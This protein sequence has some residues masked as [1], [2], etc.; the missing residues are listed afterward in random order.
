MRYAPAPP[1]EPTGPPEAPEVCPICRGA[2]WL[3]KAVPYGDSDFGKLFACRCTQAA[4]AQKH[5]ERLSQASSL[6]AFRDKTFAG[7]VR[8]VSGVQQ[9]YQ[10]AQAYARQPIGWLGLFG[11][12]GCGKTHL[13]AAIAN[14]LLAHQIPVQFVVVPDLLDHLRGAFAPD[15]TVSYDQRFDAVKQAPFLVL[16]DLGTESGTPWAK[17][18][19][20]QLVNHRYNAQLPTVFTSNTRVEQ[21]DPRI[22]SRMHDPGIQAVI[23]TIQAADYRRRRAEPAA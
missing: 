4:Q 13:A 21:L 18:K 20:Y 9:A 7:F 16:D 8:T 23:V 5:A 12:Y 10:R 11:P 6:A 22:A 17:E 19:L 1:A 2:G 15:S 14:E 3:T